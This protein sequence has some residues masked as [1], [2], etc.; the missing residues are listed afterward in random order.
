MA[1]VKGDNLTDTAQ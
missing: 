1:L